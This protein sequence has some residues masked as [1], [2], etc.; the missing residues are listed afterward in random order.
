MNLSLKFNS[1]MLAAFLVALALAAVFVNSITQ[2]TARRAVLSE[3][4]T[5]MAEVNAT[6]HYT[7]SRVTP[8]LARQ[9]AVQFTPEAIPFFAAQQ[10]FDLMSKERPD[11][12]FRQP[13]DNPTNSSDRPTSWEAEIIQT[14]RAQ[15]KLTSLTTERQT[16]AGV[17]LSLSQPV[18]VDSK[19]CLA[20]HS[21]PQAAP[22]SMVDVYGPNNGFGWKLG[23]TV[24]AQ[25]VSVPEQV[26]LTRARQ[27]LI[28]IMSAL[29]IVLAVMMLLLNLLL[30]VL[31]ITPVQRISR[32][33]DAVSLGDLA[34]PEIEHRGRDEIG[35]LAQAFNRMR[36]SLVA[37]LRLLEE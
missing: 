14:L 33:A 3:A 34:V 5:M 18:R 25:I 16:S 11:Y 6:I 27:S 29:A 9:T 8:L 21:T 17:I 28:G 24:G 30:R 4:A 36:R 2:V 31:I 13:A 12:T 26:A 32:A 37:A 19:S 1:V 22:P 20:C 35:S 23:D 15:P 10:T 7:D